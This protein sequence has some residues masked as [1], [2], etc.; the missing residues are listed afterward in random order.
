VFVYDARKRLVASYD[1]AFSQYFEPGEYTVV[2]SLCTED[3]FS[4]C[5]NTP[6]NY[7]ITIN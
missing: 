5:Y 6:I 4:Y 1:E 7:T 2:A 3:G